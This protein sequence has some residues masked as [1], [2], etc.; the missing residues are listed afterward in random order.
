MNGGNSRITS[1]HDAS[2]ST[3]AGMSGI[4]HGNFGPLKIL[5]PDQ[6]FQKILVRSDQFYL[7][8]KVRVRKKRSGDLFHTSTWLISVCE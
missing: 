4:C 2:K 8:K 7:K 6:Y 1:T 5:V 3:T